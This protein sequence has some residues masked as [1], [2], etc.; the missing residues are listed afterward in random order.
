MTKTQRVTQSVLITSHPGASSDQD[1]R[2]IPLIVRN[3]SLRLASGFSLIEML[4]VVVVL[5]VV[6]ALAVPTFSGIIE[7]D[8]LKNA[9]ERLRSDFNL[10]KT[11]SRRRN[12]NV[13]VSFTRSDDGTDWCYGLTLNAACDCTI[14]DVTDADHCELDTDIPAIVSSTTYDGVLLDALPF[15]G[16]LLL[17]AARPTLAAGSASFTSSN[18]KTARVVVSGMGRVRLCSPAGD[19]KLYSYD[20]C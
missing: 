11:E 20:P 16:D 7:R 10:A 6:L 4:V 1:P 17:S 14:T 3:S 19:N 13:T 5:S 12:R 9:A 15:G 8:H 2:S 18:A